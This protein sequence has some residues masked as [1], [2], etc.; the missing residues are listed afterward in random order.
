MGLLPSGPRCKLCLAP[1]GKPG[2]QIIRT[3]GIKQSPFNRRLCTM[4]LRHLHKIPGGAEIETTVVFADV[5]GSTALA[6]QAAPGEFGQLLARFYG[7]AARVIDRFD[8]IVDKFVGDEAVALFIPGFAGPDHAQRA[9]AAARELLL[10]TGHTEGTPWIPVGIGIHM[11]S[12][13][14]GTVGEGDALDFTAVGDT[15]NTAARLQAEAAAGEILVSDAAA[16]A[17]HLDT[18]SLERRTF[19]LRGREQS[20][21]AWVE[22]VRPV[23]VAL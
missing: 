14:V 11:G 18:S 22:A 4:C 10:E 16:N 23:A 6:E 1:F 17:A 3:L 12:A 8:G 2:R 15:V 9:I 20:V 7:T 21:E 19:E 5:R 13:F